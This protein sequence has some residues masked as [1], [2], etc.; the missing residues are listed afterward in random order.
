MVWH[1]SQLSHDDRQDGSAMGPYKGAI[2]VFEPATSGIYCGAVLG[3]S[4]EGLQ[5]PLARG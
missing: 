2:V 3:G 4:H 5:P 1:E